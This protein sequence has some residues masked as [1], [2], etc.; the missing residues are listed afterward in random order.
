MPDALARLAQLALVGDETT[1][2]EGALREAAAGVDAPLVQ[3]LERGPDGGELTVRAS[4][5]WD[6]DKG[7]GTSLPAG[8][9]SHAGFALDEEAEEP[10]RLA[11][12]RA[13]RRFTVAEAE[14]GVEVRSGVTCV[15]PGAEGPFGALSV[16]SPRA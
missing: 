13:E 12:A 16:H 15:V 6:E 8:T 14:R 5:G 2:L 3:I 9:R 4:L 1:I 7:T 10:V 11:D